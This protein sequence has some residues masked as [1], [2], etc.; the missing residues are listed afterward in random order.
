M[1]NLGLASRTQPAMAAPPFHRRLAHVRRALA[2]ATE[3]APPPPPPSPSLMLPEQASVSADG[4]TLLK[5]A[6]VKRFCTDGFLLIQPS[7]LSRDFH[8]ALCDQLVESG[9]NGDNLMAQVPDLM[10]VYTDPAVLGAARSLV[11]PGC[12]LHKH[13]HT[14]G[15]IGNPEAFQA[16]LAGWHKDPFFFEPHVRFKHSFRWVFALYFPQDTPLELGGTEI[17]R[18]SHFLPGPVEHRPGSPVEPAPVRQGATDVWPAAPLSESEAVELELPVVC[19]AG[20]SQ[21]AP[22]F[23]PSCH[24]L[25]S[26][27]AAMPLTDCHSC[28]FHRPSRLSTSI[29]GIVPARTSPTSCSDS[30]SSCITFEWKSPV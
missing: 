9:A 1:D 29:H 6:D 27:P 4:L 22:S 14:H 7:S 28:G 16:P 23:L 13:R 19:P 20:V 10:K 18:N 17:L 8:A 11:G 2:A 21:V 3:E 30:C 5:D 24:S 15:S 26:R 25:S 12:D